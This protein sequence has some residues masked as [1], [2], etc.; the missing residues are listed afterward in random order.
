MVERM[1]R[2]MEAAPPGDYGAGVPG[3]LTNRS[4]LWETEQGHVSISAADPVVEEVGGEV[5]LG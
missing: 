1:S 2:A 3:L 5:G 4:V